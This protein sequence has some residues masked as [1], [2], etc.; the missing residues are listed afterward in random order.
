MGLLS[1]QHSDATTCRETTRST[2]RLP[3]RIER[4]LAMATR[5]RGLLAPVVVCIVAVNAPNL[6][7]QG[8]SPGEYRVKAAMLYNFAKF[9]TW[10]SDPPG[11]PGE[12]FKIGI[13][14]EDPFGSV[15]DNTVKGKSVDGRAVE[16]KRLER[17]KDGR[18]CHIV[19]ISRSE[20]TNLKSILVALKG[21][22]VLTVGD[23]NRFAQQGGCINL[24]MA[25][26][27]VHFEVSVE[28]ATRARLKISSKLLRLAKVVKT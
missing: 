22:P 19:F 26:K 16:V 11:A 24:T 4:R 10:P 5:A 9:V 20:S 14:G 21:A 6:H 1:R 3:R 18:D 17:A 15:L 12:P 28:A 8:A 13:L 25:K 27:K 7:A 2:G 23:M